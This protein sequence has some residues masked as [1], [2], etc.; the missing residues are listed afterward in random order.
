MKGAINLINN[1]TNKT[2]KLNSIKKNI[3]NK[4]Y[5][6]YNLYKKEY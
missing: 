2:M 5:C 3:V 4:N 1:M 6:V